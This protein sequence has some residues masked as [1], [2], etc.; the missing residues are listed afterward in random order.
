MAINKEIELRFAFAY[1]PSEFHQTLQWIAKGKVD[2]SP[3]ITGT[4]GLDGVA[5]AFAD[6]ADP[7]RHAK[8]LIDPQRT[9]A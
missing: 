5:G 8:I 2:V 9:G 1:D 4:V 7:E 6:L 3:L